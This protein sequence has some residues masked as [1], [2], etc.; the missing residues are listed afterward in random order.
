MILKNNTTGF[1]GIHKTEYG[2]R[3]Q[4]RK[5]KKFLT[6]KRFKKFTDAFRHCKDTVRE[7]YNEFFYD[8]LEDDKINIRYSGIIKD[9]MA[10]GV[11]MGLTLFS[12]YCSIRCD[13]CQ[14]KH[15]WDKNGGNR[16]TKDIFQNIMEYFKNNSLATRLTL[17]GGEIFDNIELANY[18]ASEFKYNFP[19][20]SL[21]VYTGYTYEDLLKDV[22]YKALLEM[23]DVLVDGRFEIEN[24]DITLPYRGSSNQRL[25]NVRDSIKENKIVLLEI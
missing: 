21:W 20:K 9:D 25:I 2:W 24:R 14:N 4:V 10:N 11:G 1:R 22:K 19:D 12:Q 7:N 16:F 15:T 13:S 17:S 23:T 8:L 3:V 6:K 18:V 5:D